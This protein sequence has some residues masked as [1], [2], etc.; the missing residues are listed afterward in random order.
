MRTEHARL[1][2]PRDEAVAHQV[3]RVAK[4]H[5]VRGVVGGGVRGGGG[6]DSGRPS[7][8]APGMGVGVRAR[9][10]APSRARCN[11]GRGGRRRRRSKA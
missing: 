5:L 10:E 1:V 6:G 7:H 8:R 2:H 11:E 4:P 3:P 9:S